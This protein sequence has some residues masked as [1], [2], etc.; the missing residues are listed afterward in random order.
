MGKQLALALDELGEMLF[1]HRRC[2][3]V[4]FLPRGVRAS[5]CAKDRRAEGGGVRRLPIG[6]S[7]DPRAR[8]VEPASVMKTVSLRVRY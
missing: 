3:S 5:G 2:A 7:G 1:Q 4:Q 8:L 6:R